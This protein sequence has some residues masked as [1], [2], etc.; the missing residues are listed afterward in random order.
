MVAFVSRKSK[1]KIEIAAPSV[2]GGAQR[3]AL[4]GP[5][6]LLEG[7]D[8]ATYDQFLARVCVAVKPVDIID[9]MHIADV[10]Y[11]GWEVLRYRRLKWRLIREFGLEVLQRFLSEH[12]EYDL[13]SEYFKDDLAEILEDNLPEDQ[14][15]SAEMLAREYARNEP[16]AVEKVRQ[17]LAGMQLH[18][19]SPA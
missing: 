5:P 13:Y 3:L 9:E 18:R 2:A 6:L 8:A 12:L 10:V 14:A 16:D 17:I 1:S 11:S 19:R 7:E 4:F 15:D